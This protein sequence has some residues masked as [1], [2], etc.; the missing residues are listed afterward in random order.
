[1]LKAPLRG[2]NLTDKIDS[3]HYSMNKKEIIK[4]IIEIMKKSLIVRKKAITF[5]NEL[6]KN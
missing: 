1:M 2:T 6:N 5:S 4:N 3:S